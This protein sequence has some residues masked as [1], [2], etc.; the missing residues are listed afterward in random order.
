MSSFRASFCDPFK[1]DI[2][3]LGTIAEADII[4]TFE[5]IPWQEYLTKMGEVSD[6]EIFFSPSLEVEN[7]QTRH[8]LS[9]SAVGDANGY[10]FI[11]FYKRPKMVKVFFGLKQK[12]DNNY[13]SDRDGMSAADASDC[14]R[15][16]IAG[17]TAYLEATIGQ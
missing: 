12:M 6:K 16:L 7:R 14:L 13:L 8:G 2:V 11:V 3:E 15:A 1:P 9:I 17:D 4:P 5:K 10:E